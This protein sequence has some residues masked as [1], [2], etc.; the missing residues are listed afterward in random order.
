MSGAGRPH[1]Y[2]HLQPM[3][4]SCAKVCTWRKVLVRNQLCAT[5]F[6]QNDHGIPIPSSPLLNRGRCLQCNKG[7][8]HRVA[9]QENAGT[10]RQS[11]QGSNRRLEL[12]SEHGESTQRIQKLSSTFTHVMQSRVSRRIKRDREREREKGKC[13]ARGLPGLIAD[14]ASSFP[15]QAL[16]YLCKRSTTGTTTTAAASTRAALATLPFPPPKTMSK[17]RQRNA[18]RMSNRQ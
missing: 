3:Q 8:H 9:S 11:S 13:K 16:P 17:G 14:L 1:R 2:S 7:E 10:T 5:S 12:A 15:T 18:N 6:T 4:S